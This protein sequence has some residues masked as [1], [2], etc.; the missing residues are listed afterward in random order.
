MCVDLD[1]Q[2]HP[3]G[4]SAERHGEEGVERITTEVVGPFTTITEAWTLAMALR[5]DLKPLTLF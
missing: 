2:G 1:D 4:V 5:A 3:L